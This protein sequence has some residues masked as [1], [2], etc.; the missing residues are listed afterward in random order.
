M[1]TRS[2]GHCVACVAV[3]VVVVVA[4]CMLLVEASR[5]DEEPVFVSCVANCERTSCRGEH[6]KSPTLHLRSVGSHL[7]PTTSPRQLLSLTPACV[8]CWVWGF[9]VARLMG[10]TCEENCRYECMHQ[11]SDMK[12]E[13]GEQLVCT[14]GLLSFPPQQWSTCHLTINANWRDY[15]SNTMANGPLLA[16]WACK[17]CSQCCFPLAT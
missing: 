15:R 16:C 2:P 13:R 10:W 12:D 8:L 7:P 17:S 14:R 4:A 6:A 1:R 3:A 5:G 11:V 9:G